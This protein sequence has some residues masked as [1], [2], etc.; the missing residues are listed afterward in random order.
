MITDGKNGGR[1]EGEPIRE[2]G[3]SDSQLVT[4]KELWE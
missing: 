2:K 1:G 3:W 4:R